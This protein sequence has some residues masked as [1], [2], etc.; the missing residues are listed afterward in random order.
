MCSD[1]KNIEQE[2]VYSPT[3]AEKKV[4]FTT[5]VTLQK[6][7]SETSHIASPDQ[8]KEKVV[9]RVLA[10]KKSNLRVVVTLQKEN[11]LENCPME[12][13]PESQ[14]D[15]SISSDQ[16]CASSPVLKHKG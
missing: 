10:E 4:K 11:T 6:E 3:T 16:G 12:S 13:S 2:Q 7:N 1:Q 5:I 8:T 15:K 9:K 14:Q